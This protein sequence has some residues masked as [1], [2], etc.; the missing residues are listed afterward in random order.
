MPVF[1]GVQF[2]KLPWDS[3]GQSVLYYMPSNHTK[4]IEGSVYD[5]WGSDAE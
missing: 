2:L 3:A 1:A 5:S 4:K